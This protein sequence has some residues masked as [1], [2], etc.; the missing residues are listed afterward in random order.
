MRKC[1][2]LVTLSLD[3]IFVCKSDPFT[4]IS[5]DFLSQ[6]FLCL[7]CSELPFFCI[8]LYVWSYVRPGRSRLP[9]LFTD[10]S[11]LSFSVSAAA[12]TRTSEAPCRCGRGV[13]YRRPGLAHACMPLFCLYMYIN[14]LLSILLWERQVAVRFSSLCVSWI[15]PEF[16]PASLIMVSPKL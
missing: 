13:W 5:Y 16:G 7:Q 4:A 8:N 3:W 15:L 9:A 14:S 12:W 11:L 1:C 2:N 6:C 10:P